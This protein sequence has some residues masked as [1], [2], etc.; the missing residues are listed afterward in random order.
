[1]TC[2]AQGDWPPERCYSLD[3]EG[4]ARRIEE[5]AKKTY[6]ELLQLQGTRHKRYK[7]VRMQAL[8]KLS[9]LISNY[10]NYCCMAAGHIVAI[11]AAI[12]VISHW[13][14]SRGPFLL[15]CRK[16]NST[17]LSDEWWLP[18]RWS[19]PARCVYAADIWQIKFKLKLTAMWTSSSL[20]HTPPF[21]DS[22]ATSN[23]NKFPSLPTH[24]ACTW[25][26]FVNLVNLLILAYFG[27]TWTK[28][29][30]PTAPLSQHVST[31]KCC[32]A[33]FDLCDLCI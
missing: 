29:S 5:T 26:F 6:Q 20:G 10:Y 15:K 22:L 11:R 2:M 7:S 4:K 32:Q 9:E 23:L 33:V 27:R 14:V 31:V 1:M 25:T 24:D 28:P 18:G 17:T 21:G 30:T 13:Q 12:I 8:I 3:E 16:L 19:A